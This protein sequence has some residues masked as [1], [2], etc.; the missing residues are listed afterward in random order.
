M[1]G[2]RIELGPIVVIFLIVF[3]LTAVITADIRIKDSLLNLAK[4]EAQVTGAEIINQVVNEQVVSTVQYADIVSIHKDEHGKIALIQLDTFML[5]KIMSNIVIE[6]AQSLGQM[7]ANV[8]EIPL[9]Q[10]TG[11]ELLAGYGPKLN[12]KTI[13]A[14]QIHVEVMNKFEQAGINQT[15]HMIYFEIKCSMLVAVPFMKDE[16]EV[17]TTVPLAESIIV[18]DVPQTYV[19]FSGDS[20]LL[21]PLIKGD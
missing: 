20:S 19:N 12:V 3:I 9:G 5:N 15:R 14:G 4:A 2:R 21:Y 10:L 13:P 8:L 6:V 16:V 18:G 11:S 1:Y 7:E 17:K